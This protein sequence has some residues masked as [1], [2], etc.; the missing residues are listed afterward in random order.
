LFSPLEAAKRGTI[1]QYLLSDAGQKAMWPELK[2]LLTKGKALYFSHG[3]SVVYKDQTGVVPPAD[4]DVILV[5]PKGA[6]RTVRDNFLAGSGINS[7]YA[8]CGSIVYVYFVPHRNCATGKDNVVYYA[9][10]SYVSSWL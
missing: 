9:C 1:V 3:F 5:A 6:G 4:I 2:P 8:V 7:S 10:F